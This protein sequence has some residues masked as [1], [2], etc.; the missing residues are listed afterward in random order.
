[1]T[2]ARCLVPRPALASQLAGK[3]SHVF[4]SAVHGVSLGGQ[5]KSGLVRC[6]RATG[7]GSTGDA[8]AAPHAEQRHRPGRSQGC[9]ATTKAE[10]QAGQRG[11]SRPV[12]PMSGGGRLVPP[13]RVSVVLIVQAT[14]PS[15]RA[16][17]H[18]AQA[19]LASSSRT[20]PCTPVDGTN[21][22][23]PLATSSRKRIAW[24]VFWIA[25]ASSGGAGS[26]SCSAT[27]PRNGA[28]RAMAHACTCGGTR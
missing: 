18:L 3:C 20:A 17:A 14:F 15:S 8:Q 23:R 11:S 10:P 21:G 25:D 1:M 9:G 2:A 7:P 12:P 26:P 16:P 22:R 4:D 19:S 5:G 28:A 6:R 27:R 13:G 24:R